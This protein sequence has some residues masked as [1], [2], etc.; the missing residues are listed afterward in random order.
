VRERDALA[1]ALRTAPDAASPHRRFDARAPRG[2]A[3]PLVRR[4]AADLQRELTLPSASRHG[5]S[6]SR[7]SIAVSRR[8]PG[9]AR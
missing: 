1:H 3:A 2:A 8:R 7:A 5:S 9:D 6:A 4:D